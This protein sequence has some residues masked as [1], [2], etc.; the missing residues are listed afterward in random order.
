M[1]AKS[2][3]SSLSFSASMESSS[4]STIRRSN[5]IDMQTFER[6][7]E[8]VEKRYEVVTIDDIAAARREGAPHS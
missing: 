7:V 8:L 6:I 2:P 1:S 3:R 5:H 4:A